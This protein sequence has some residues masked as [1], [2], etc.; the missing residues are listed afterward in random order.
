LFY[1]SSEGIIAPP[2]PRRLRRNKTPSILIE[3]NKSFQ[4]R[5]IEMYGND[6][7]IPYFK[8]QKSFRDHTI[9]DQKDFNNHLSYISQNA[10]KHELVQEPEQWP[11]MWIEGESII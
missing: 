2:Q 8:W 3:R 1:K 6:C 11:W 5:F 4:K 9:R 7:N 10:V